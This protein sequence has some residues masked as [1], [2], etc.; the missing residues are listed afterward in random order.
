MNSYINCGAY[1][2]CVYKAVFGA[3]CI[4]CKWQLV[5]CAHAL[6]VTVEPVFVGFGVH[7]AETNFLTT[8]LHP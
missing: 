2:E 4:S 7:G 1:V 3:L 6:L 5:Q 8:L